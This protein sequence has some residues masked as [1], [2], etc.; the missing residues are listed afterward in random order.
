MLVWAKSAGFVP[1]MDTLLMERLVLPVLVMVI[2]WVALVA[3]ANALNRSGPAGLIE[4]P[5]PVAASLSPGPLRS[6][7]M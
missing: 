7:V 4:R 5:G 1:M 6:A 2:V 3:P